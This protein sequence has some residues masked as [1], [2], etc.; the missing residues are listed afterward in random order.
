L[1]RVEHV[2]VTMYAEERQQAM[3]RLVAERVRLSVNE[4]AERYGIGVETV[5]RDL[6]ALER[7]GLVHRVHGGV[8]PANTLTVIEPDFVEADSANTVEKERIAKAALAFLPPA[9]ST[10]LMDAGS[11]T[12]RLAGMLPRDH[13]LVVFTHAIP[14]AARLTGHTQVELH[15][16]PGRVRGITRAAVGSDTVAALAELRVDA[17]FLGTHAL[18]LDHGLSTPDRDEA[19]IKRAIVRSARQVIVLSDASKL[20]RESLV[21]FAEIADIDVLVTDA[22]ISDDDRSALAETGPEVVVAC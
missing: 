17:A 22:G 11:T 13:R 19:A 3:A 15:L 5:R 2:A 10:V 9:G 16:L 4:L 20:G 12:S 8:V 6:S 7:M 21:R 18:S 14:I 1:L